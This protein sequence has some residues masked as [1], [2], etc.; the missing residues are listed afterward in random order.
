MKF[1][2]CDNVKCFNSFIR[3]NYISDYIENIGLL[4]CWYE[5]TEVSLPQK[6]K[7]IIL[8]CILMNLTRLKIK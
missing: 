4:F 7:K 1:I 5:K 8:I 3:V 6:G 2:L